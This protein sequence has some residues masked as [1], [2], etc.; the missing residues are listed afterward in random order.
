MQL[1]GPATV[2]L[3]AY[4][5]FIDNCASLEVIETPAPTFVV[6]GYWFKA[7]TFDRENLI[8]Q[9]STYALNNVLFRGFS[10]DPVENKDDLRENYFRPTLDDHGF[11]W[12]KSDGTEVEVSDTEAEG[13]GWDAYAVITEGASSGHYCQLTET[14]ASV[15]IWVWEGTSTI[16][17]Q[18]LT[19][20][21]YEYVCRQ[22]ANSSTEPS[23]WARNCADTEC[24]QCTI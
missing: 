22:G 3:S 6:K 14:E 4:P 10:S 8:S 5:N 9:S 12:V 18:T 24:T 11:T 19:I 21:D 16:D 15:W 20:E 23:C 7:I 17:T 2:D 13:Q 1:D